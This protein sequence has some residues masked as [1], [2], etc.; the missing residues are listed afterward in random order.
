MKSF[1]LR[2]LAS[3]ALVLVS[4][5]PRTFNAAT[6]SSNAATPTPVATPTK[7]A[8]VDL[9]PQGRPASY[10]V[11]FRHERIYDCGQNGAVDVIW[12]QAGS[13]G[14]ALA[15]KAQYILGLAAH[16]KD[17]NQGEVKFSSVSIDSAPAFSVGSE[18]SPVSYLRPMFV[19]DE[20]EVKGKLSYHSAIPGMTG[21]TIA[22][23]G[24]L[25][26]PF[27][28]SGNSVSVAVSLG[29]SV[30]GPAFQVIADCSPKNDKIKNWLTSC[31]GRESVASNSGC[32]H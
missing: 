28:G 2:L 16:M 1:S 11:Q 17:A 20:A 32:Q 8:A 18:P 30:R 21:R 24:T 4:C 19:F 22:A 13:D 12:R 31:V 6:Q 3:A 5:K 26:A 14:K 27:D 15:P 9:R 7:S 23:G 25:W 29:A 10:D